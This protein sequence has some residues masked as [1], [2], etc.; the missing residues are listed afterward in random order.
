MLFHV[1]LTFRAIPIFISISDSDG[2]IF[3]PLSPKKEVEA[4]EHEDHTENTALREQVIRIWKKITCQP[5][6]KL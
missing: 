6:V 5:I 2:E 1:A 3:F 4:G